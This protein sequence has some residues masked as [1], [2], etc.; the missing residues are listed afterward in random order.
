M[1]QDLCLGSGTDSTCPSPTRR[2]DIVATKENERLTSDLL[3]Q[4]IKEKQTN[5]LLFYPQA[6]SALI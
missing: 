4:I 3:L 5:H 1:R 6:A 2:N